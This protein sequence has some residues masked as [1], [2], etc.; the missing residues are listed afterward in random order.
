MAIFYKTIYQYLLVYLEALVNIILQLEPT[1]AQNKL[2][3][4][5]EDIYFKKRML[6]FM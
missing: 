6:N 2:F 1:Q 4:L 5:V 3:R